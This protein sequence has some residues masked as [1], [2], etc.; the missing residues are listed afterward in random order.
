MKITVHYNTTITDP[1]SIKNAKYIGD[2]AIR[3][4]FNN[5]KKKL[6]D[7]KPFLN[8]SGHPAIK[9][10]LNEQLFLKFQI[11]NGN[12][13]WNDYDLIFPINELYTNSIKL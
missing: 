12:L 4:E 2:F 6:V 1:I 8:N 9:K 7:F 13:N 11:K 10:Y 3:L 5:Q